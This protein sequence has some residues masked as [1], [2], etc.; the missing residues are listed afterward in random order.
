VS[1]RSGRTKIGGQFSWR[2]I[3]MLESPAYRALSL[4]ARRLLDR[5]EIEL[6]HHGGD[7]NGRLPATYEQLHEYG[8]DRDSIPPAIRET[9]ALGFLEVTEQGRAGN[10]EFRTPSRYRLTYRPAGRANATDDWRQIKTD[11]QAQALAKLARGVDRKARK[12]NFGRG[13]S[14]VS[15]GETPTENVILLHGET[16][17][18]V[19]DGETPTT[20]ISRG[21]DEQPPSRQR[22][23]SACSPQGKRADERR[24]SAITATSLYA[25]AIDARAS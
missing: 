14:E 1:R 4:S 10:R 25:R 2:L 7:D 19:P 16:P 20:S 21:G 23:A 8:I 13:F 11:E 17:T 3:E 5:L 12:K 9:V 22:A 24:T 6:A 15:H 18:T